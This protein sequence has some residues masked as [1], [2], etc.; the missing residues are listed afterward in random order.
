M[1]E[2]LSEGQAGSGQGTK[3]IYFPACGIAWAAVSLSGLQ[4]SGSASLKIADIKSCLDTG[5]DVEESSS[6]RHRHLECV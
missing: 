1:C 2:H 5:L 3:L 6:D 4:T